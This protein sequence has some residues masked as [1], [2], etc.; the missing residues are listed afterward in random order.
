M[1]ASA[2]IQ[3]LL[4]LPTVIRARLSPDRQWVA[5]E[6][7]RVHENLDVFVVPVAG[8]REPAA[9]THTSETTRLVS[10]VPDSGSVI[11]AQDKDGNERAQLFRVF[12]ERPLNMIALTEEDPA[13]FI[14]GGELHPNGRWLVYGAN[15]D[16]ETGQEIEPTWLYRHDLETGERLALA[17]PERAAEYSPQLNRGGT[18]VLYARKDRHPSGRQVW[19]VDIE[20]REDRELFNFGDAYKVHAHWL[21]DGRRIVV[22]AESTDGGP[23]DHISIGLYD[24]G[25]GELDWLVDDPARQF[26]PPDWLAHSDHIVLHE[27]MDARPRP[28]LLNPDSGVERPF[29]VWSGNLKPVG[30]AKEGEWVALYYSAAQPADLV[31]LSLTTLSPSEGVSLT[32]VWSRTEL[33]PDR[34]VPAEDFRWRSLDGLEIQG[35][36][37]R[38]VPSTDRAIIFIHGGP[39]S[40]SEDWLNAQIQYF[41]SRGFNVL[42][43]NYRGST[44]FGLKFREAIKEDGWGG[45]EQEDI[46]AGAQALIT[47]GLAAPGQVG[48]TGTSYGGYSAWFAITHQPPEIIAAA[49]PVCGM[50]DL[51][52]DFE[53][54]LPEVRTLS[55]EMMGGRPD[56]VP[57]RYFERSPINFVQNIHGRVLIVQG[58]QDPNVTPENVRQVVQR[59]Q[60]AGKEYQLLVFEDEG[61]GISRLENQARL[62]VELAAFFESAF[63]GYTGPGG[64]GEPGDET[65]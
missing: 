64:K 61:H 46:A 45:R 50:T 3:Q 5:F 1:S 42:D 48:V 55:E 9:L 44:G 21:P 39:N 63:E 28:S 15:Y 18:H 37:Y 49:A 17:R 11:V 30:Q 65:G 62:Y 36:V 22:H 47:A 34:L 8:R 59:L 7:Y 58:A 25:T 6:W 13:Y 56:Q 52:L 16:Y 51:V 60:T 23:Q 12:L 26:E 10:W 14:Q 19:L 40:H 31:R 32:D 4:S 2:F 24:T 20:G 57:E 35:W 41:V 29:P 33:A 38:A 53:T 54:T 27:V 43:P